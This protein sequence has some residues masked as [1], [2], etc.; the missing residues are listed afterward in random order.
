MPP[1]TRK[2]C[3]HGLGDEQ[4]VRPSDSRTQLSRD[5][6]KNPQRQMLAWEKI[7]RLGGGG[8]QDFRGPETVAVHLNSP[9]SK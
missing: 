9:V 7:T 1:P 6:N 3:L 8:G 2:R 5:Q 4:H